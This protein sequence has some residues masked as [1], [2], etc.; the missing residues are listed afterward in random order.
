MRLAYAH[1]S[2]KS[3]DDLIGSLGVDL[4]YFFTEWFSI[5]LF[6]NLSFRG[7]SN[8]DFDF[9]RLDIGGGLSLDAKF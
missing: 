1:Y 7:S 3:R 2:N 5:G 6:S 4:D 8:D 9:N